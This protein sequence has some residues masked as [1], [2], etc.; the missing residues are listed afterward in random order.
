MQT[1]LKE[2]AEQIQAKNIKAAQRARENMNAALRGEGALDGVN[3]VLKFLNVKG[4]V[5]DGL[6]ISEQLRQ[7][8]ERFSIKTR[9]VELDEDWYT[10]AAIPMIVKTQED[11]WYAV[12]PKPD[13]TCFYL[14]RGKKVKVTAKKAQFF[15]N[16]AL[17]FYKVLERGPVTA[18]ALFSFLAKCISKRGVVTVL[19]ASALTA[20]AGMLVPWANRFIFSR[21]VPAG[22]ASG[23]G[24]A[25]ALILSAVLTAAILGLLRSLV[26]TNAMLRADTYIQSAIFS[27]LLSLKAEFFKTARSGELSRVITE[28]AD[29]TKIISARGISACVGMALSLVYLIQIYRYAPELLG[30]IVLSTVLLGAM[31]AAESVWSAKWM[32]EYSSSLSKMSGFCYE[33]FS[34]IEQIKLNGAEER[35]MWRWSEHYL[36]TSRKEDKP[37]LLKYSGVF[38]KLIRILTTAAIFLFGAHLAAPDYIAFSAAYG[39]YAAAS[40]G[41]AVIIQMWASFRSMY[42]TIAP[43]LT[44][45]REEQGP[46]Q[47]KPEALRGEITVSD[48]R[49][50][51]EKDGPYILNG[52][53]AHIRPGESVG[54]VGPSGCGKSTLIRLLLGFEQPQQGTVYLDGF[55]LRELDLQS[56]RQKIGT[57]LQNTGLISGDIYSNIT[58]TKPDATME[59]VAQAVELAGLSDTIDALPMGLRTPVS[60][61]NCTLS[62]GQRQR[63]LIARAILSRPSILIFDEATSALDNITQAQIT[64]SVNS[65]PC[66]KLIVAHRLSTIEHCDR[67]FVM[68]QGGIAQQGTWNELKDAGGL[69]G[70]LMRRQ[71]VC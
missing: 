9:Y 62:G 61:E 47:K 5:D 57:V 39:A 37:F 11:R 36:G 26:L 53:S 48:L 10:A 35:A 54:I 18:G 32:S 40:T 2:E 64:Q 42:A 15:T 67:I 19:A 56:C 4:R 65:L 16:S 1:K 43:V 12:I 24:A 6:P 8:E 50:R 38:Y 31:M 29:I 30:W 58:L 52:L 68:D 59:E 21:I 51:Y 23:I 71:M 49:F 27:R 70:Q 20:L 7:M 41:A 66:T 45:Q 44:A 25:A 14:N 60:Q 69:F 17:C 3:A 55:D 22:D 33:L 46:Q 34:G 28:I 13:G 63:V